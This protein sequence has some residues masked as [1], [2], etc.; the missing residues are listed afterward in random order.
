VGAPEGR[1]PWLKETTPWINVVEVD[2]PPKEDE[3]DPED[4][5]WDADEVHEMMEGMDAHNV[6]F[7]R[8]AVET[9]YP[10]HWESVHYK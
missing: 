3:D 5:P 7:H 2:W 10:R 4:P 8:A 1:S 6:G 9:L